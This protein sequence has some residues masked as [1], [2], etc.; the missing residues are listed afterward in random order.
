LPINIAVSLLP[1]VYFGISSFEAIFLTLGFFTSIFIKE[2]RHKNEYLFYYNNGI[3][4]IK[5]WLFSYILNF[6][7]LVVIVIIFNLI[8]KLL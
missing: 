3:S 1:L 8:M 2:V 4:K 6:F 5:L 7:F